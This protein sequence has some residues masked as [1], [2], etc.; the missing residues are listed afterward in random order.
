MGHHSYP[1]R[2]AGET[3]ILAKGKLESLDETCWWMAAEWGTSEGVSGTWSFLLRSI[4]RAPALITP[5]PPP[6]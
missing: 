4:D 2:S 1:S 6:L 5:P 3:V